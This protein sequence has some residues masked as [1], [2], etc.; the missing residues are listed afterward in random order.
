VKKKKKKLGPEGVRGRFAGGGK[1]F[2]GEFSLKLQRKK[3]AWQRDTGIKLHTNKSKTVHPKKE[4]ACHL[5]S[6]GMGNVECQFELQFKIVGG[7]EVVT[8]TKKKKKKN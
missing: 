5:L 7:Q 4:R 6:T 8:S 2:Y 3:K 1:K